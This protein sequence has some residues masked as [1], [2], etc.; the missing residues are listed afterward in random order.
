M[1]KVTVSAEE[2]ATTGKGAA[3]TLR[4]AGNVPAV[5]YNM[6]KAAPITLNGKELLGFIN[7]TRGE[8]VLVDLKMPKGNKLVVIKEFQVDPIRGNLLHADL[9][10]VDINKPI[11]VEVKV[12][13]IGEPIGVKR[14][15]GILQKMLRNVLVE[16]LPTNIPGHFDVDITNLASGQ[17]M[18]VSDIVAPS[19]I[20]I[21]TDPH[22]PI[23]TVTGLEKETVE[24]VAAA[25][26]A[27]AAAEGEKKEKG[28][29]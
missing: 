8:Q 9:I 15:K 18:H 20:K 24:E 1:E 19:D 28:A 11:R 17:S 21:L 4:R 26:A 10:E 3:R 5:I 27:P 6:G 7:R 29:A 22:E 13:V 14:D 2:R 12:N 16:A 23:C 25:A